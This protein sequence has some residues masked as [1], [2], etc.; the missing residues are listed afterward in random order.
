MEDIEGA[1]LEDVGAFFQTYYVPNNAVLT[2]VGDVD[3]ERALEM[4]ETYFGEIP[5]GA[6]IP[7]LPGTV[8]IPPVIGETVWELVEGDVPLPR[9]YMAARVP[10]LTAEGFHPAEVAATVLGSGHASRMYRSLV[11]EQRI[12]KDVL[13]YIFPLEAGASLLLLWVT[14]YPGANPEELE[15]ALVAEVDGLASVDQKELDR[16][17]AMT[18]THLLREIQQVGER[19]DLLSM[20]DQIFDDPGRLNT[21]VERVR[22]VTRDQVQDFA[23]AYLGPDNRAFLTYVPGGAQ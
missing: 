20:F 7:P 12:A 10:P 21:E 5:Q 16:A 9:V 4:A 6:P 17:V 18:E 1:T 8:D 13:S 22:A 19:A 15:K 23:G 11:R 14:G 2:L 3:P